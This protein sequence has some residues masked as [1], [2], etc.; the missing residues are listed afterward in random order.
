MTRLDK[1]P[2]R[3]GDDTPAVK[4][5]DDY[6]SRFLA[7]EKRALEAERDLDELTADMK[8]FDAVFDNPDV[9]AAVEKAIREDDGDDVLSEAFPIIFPGEDSTP[10]V[11]REWLEVNW[12]PMGEVT[13]VYG[14]GGHGKSLL[15]TQLAVSVAMGKEVLGWRPRKGKVLYVLAEDDYEKD[16]KPRLDRICAFYGMSRLDLRQDFITLPLNAVDNAAFCRFNRKTGATETTPAWRRVKEL[17]VSHKPTLVVYDTMIDLFGGSAIVPEQFRAFVRLLKLEANEHDHAAALL[18]HS[19][20]S[21]ISDGSGTGGSLAGSNAAR[22]RLYQT[23]NRDTGI[24]TISSMKVNGGEDGSKVD[25]EWHKG[26]FIARA[27]QEE[28]DPGYVRG[29]VVDFLDKLEADGSLAG[30][31]YVN[32]IRTGNYAP[33]IFSKVMDGKVSES[34]FEKAIRDMKEDGLIHE[35]SHKVTSGRETA[36]LMNVEVKWRRKTLSG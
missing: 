36:K 25:F 17:I 34:E 24:F 31:G 12:Y 23:K 3:I 33:R 19:S 14:D 8:K 22:S 35:V 26:V 21:G 30:V 20:K 13:L 29:L 5:D 27:A 11:P 4:Q 6:R 2:R 9:R 7:M 16:F 28:S 1:D 18:A 15:H 10:T 32:N